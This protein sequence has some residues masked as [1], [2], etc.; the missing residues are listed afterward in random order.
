MGRESSFIQCALRNGIRLEEVVATHEPGCHQ[1]HDR[2]SNEQVFFRYD[3][4][5]FWFPLKKSIR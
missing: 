3:F 1:R 5:R 4:H 2:R